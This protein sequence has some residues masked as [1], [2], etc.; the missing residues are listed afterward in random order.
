MKT[1]YF[2]MFG[3]FLG[4]YEVDITTV[5]ENYPLSTVFDGGKSI[6]LCGEPNLSLGLKL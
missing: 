1:Y 2:Y 3:S 6:E 4:S 5:K